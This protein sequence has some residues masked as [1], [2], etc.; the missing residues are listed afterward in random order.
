ML[1]EILEEMANAYGVSPRELTIGQV[2]DFFQTAGKRR[3]EKEEK[4]RTERK[5][6]KEREENNKEEISREE[7]GVPSSVDFEAEFESLWRRYPRKDGKKQA[8]KHYTASRRRGVS[9]ITI[10][11]G[12]DRYVSYI[13]RNGVKPEYV[14]MG[15]SWFSQEAWNDELKDRTVSYGAKAFKNFDERNTD[16]D[17]LL[18]QFERGA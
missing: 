10:S 7:K 12:I 1:D 13:Q 16:Y 4:K 5:E 2:A 6:A 17:R 9:Y 14:K 15:S 11:D 18:E 8:Y 3:E